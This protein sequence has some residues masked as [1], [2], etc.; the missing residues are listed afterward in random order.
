MQRLS[1]LWWSKVACMAC[2]PVI[3]DTELFGRMAEDIARYDP[4]MQHSYY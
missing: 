3:E 1:P 2:R 4:A